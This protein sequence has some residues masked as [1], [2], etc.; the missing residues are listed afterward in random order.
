MLVLPDK[1]EE[2]LLQHYCK[3]IRYLQPRFGIRGTKSIQTILITCLVFV[4]LELLRGT[5]KRAYDHL[6]GGV[7]LLS[8]LHEDTNKTFSRPGPSSTATS[9]LSSNQGRVNAFLIEA[10]ARLRIQLE[11]SKLRSGTGTLL[12][13]ELLRVLPTLGFT[14]FSE[15]RHYLDRVLD[16]IN[17]L[18]QAIRDG[19]CE[20]WPDSYWNMI[21]TER[22]FMQGSL[23]LWLRSYAA[24]MAVRA[25]TTNNDD[26]NGYKMLRIYHT[27]AEIMGATCLS[28]NQSAFDQYNSAF[29]SIVSQCHNIASNGEPS[30]HAL[31]GSCRPDP[32]RYAWP[33]I[34]WIPP[35]YFTAIKCRDHQIR[36]QALELMSS[37]WRYEIV[38]DL[39][40]LDISS[41][42]AKEVIRMEE[43]DHFKASCL[44]HLGKVVTDGHQ[45][46]GVGRLLPLPEEQRFNTVEM[47]IL[48]D[49]SRNIRIVCKSQC[50]GGTKVI[51]KVF[52]Q[53]ES[54]WTKV[55]THII[56]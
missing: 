25:S 19:A 53:T 54:T 35:L 48:D 47:F 29:L 6:E 15:A 16:A 14:S 51:Q 7:K 5:Y 52:D 41:I 42:V 10:F 37:F 26:L 43:G 34:S 39:G 21:L 17:L 31:S 1:Q 28:Q 56:S 24:T 20:T 22:R 50:K 8:F 4:Y 9:S 38:W 55:E 11:F 45:N 12:A 33:D 18:A 2:F 49:T 32:R 44:D 27:M 40:I 36:T 46:S 30:T 23:D 3:S 13:P